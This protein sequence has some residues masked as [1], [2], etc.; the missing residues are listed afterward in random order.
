MPGRRQQNRDEQCQSSQKGFQEVRSW[1]LTYPGRVFRVPRNSQKAGL[2]LTS[3]N[4]LM[5]TTS[6]DSVVG[7]N[8]PDRT[9]C[10]GRGP[11]P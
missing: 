7:G 3:E 9:S 2:G 6:M 4:P 10:F 8:P 1:V 11:E 5:E